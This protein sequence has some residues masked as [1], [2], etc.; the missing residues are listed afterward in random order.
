MEWQLRLDRD[1]AKRDHG[2]E[3]VL[4]GVARLHVLLLSPG[5]RY[6]GHDFLADA[7]DLH[8]DATRRPIVQSYVGLGGRNERQLLPLYVR[9]FFQVRGHADAD[10]R[11]GET[12]RH[13]RDHLPSMRLR[14]GLLRIVTPQDGQLVLATTVTKKLITVATFSTARSGSLS[15]KVASSAKNVYIDGVAIRRN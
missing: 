10:R 14:H 5:A 12:D 15:I 13:R 4:H 2:H 11:R 3:R 8:G 7:G 6:G 9:A 1:L